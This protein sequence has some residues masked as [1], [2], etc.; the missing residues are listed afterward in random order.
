MQQKSLHQLNVE[1]FATVASELLHRAGHD[2]KAQLQR[3]PLKPITDDELNAAAGMRKLRA[4]LI[5]EECL[6][7]ITALGCAVVDT[8][9]GYLLD[10]K[11]AKAMLTVIVEDRLNVADVIDGCCDIRVVTTGTLSAMGIPDNPFQTEVDHNNLTKLDQGVSV[12]PN[13]KIL[14]PPNHK[15]PMITEMLDKMRKDNI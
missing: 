9:T 15:P 8:R 5:L 7:T 11:C 3:V 1:R 2:D 12:S 4:N 14:K 6:E 13:G 10:S